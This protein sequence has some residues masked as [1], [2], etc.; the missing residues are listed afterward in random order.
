MLSFLIA[1]NKTLNRS[2][3]I[4]FSLCYNNS[5]EFM[6]MIVFIVSIVLVLIDQVLKGLVIN[7]LNLYESVDIIPNFLSITYV[8]NDGAAFNILSGGRWFFIIAGLIA[9]IFIIKFIMLD[10][11]VSKFDRMAYSLVLSGIVG[12]LIDRIFYGK[13][14]DYIDF[15]LFGY[16]A[17]IFNFADI[18]I[19]VGVIM[20]VF[21]LIIKGD[22]DGNIYSR[23]RTK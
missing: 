16:D 19:V 10:T 5:G 23:K 15:N 12:N 3:S 20:I 17:P 2:I 13:V 11:K 6:K 22:S 4:I 7:S 8:T 14:I 21:I 9:L 1:K 18:C